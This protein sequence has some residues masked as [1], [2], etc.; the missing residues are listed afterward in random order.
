MYDP[1][2]LYTGLNLLQPQLKFKVEVSYFEIYS[3]RIYDLLIPES[4]SSKHKV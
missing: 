4:R 3:E 2:V 1:V